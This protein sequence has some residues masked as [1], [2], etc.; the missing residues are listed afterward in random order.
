MEQ[1]DSQM[2][3]RVW[4]RVQGGITEENPIQDLL[5]F[6]QEE[7]T[8]LTYYRQLSGTSGSAAKP[9][10][11]QLIKATQQCVFTL[12]GIHL[13]LIGTIP[14]AKAFPL[15]KELP[16]AALR[17]SYGNTLRRSAR[18]EQWSSHREYGCAFSEMTVLSQ[19]RCCLL[20]QLIGIRH[21]KDN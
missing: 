4:Q 15:P 19:K 12:R 13:L 16:N 3:A 7:L 9:E 1:Y 20:L 8:D 18:Y 6:L 11:Q 21:S 14:E 2:A 10:L 17:R 5:I